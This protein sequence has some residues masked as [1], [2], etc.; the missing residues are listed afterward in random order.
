MPFPQ[1]SLL[2]LLLTKLPLPCLVFLQF[3]LISFLFSLFFI[4]SSSL[5]SS[6]SEQPSHLNRVCRCAPV[7]LKSGWRRHLVPDLFGLGG[8]L[9]LV[10]MTVVIKTINPNVYAKAAAIEDILQKYAENKGGNNRVADFVKRM[11]DSDP[12]NLWFEV[13]KGVDEQVAQ[14]AMLM[15]IAIENHSAVG[16]A[17][18][19]RFEDVKA[20]WKKTFTV[21]H[22]D[23]TVRFRWNREELNVTSRFFWVGQAMSNRQLCCAKMIHHHLA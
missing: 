4:F 14:H 15:K 16:M 20:K 10:T 22:L 5:S 17:W 1:I 2:A 6:C 7:K 3:F 11:D 8:I 12:T 13:F 23:K 18:N 19:T 9:I 21:I